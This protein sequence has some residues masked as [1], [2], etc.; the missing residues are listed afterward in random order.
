[1]VGRRLRAAGAYK[2][3]AEQNVAA[4]ARE[5]LALM[6]RI[7]RGE[8]VPPKRFGDLTAAASSGQDI[9]AYAQMTPAQRQVARANLERNLAL[10][11]GV[12]SQV[13]LAHA[14]RAERPDDL[15][16]SQPSAGS[17]ACL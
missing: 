10:E 8:P 13:H 1:M 3:G 16:G 12:P 11:S 15:V 9:S 2:T 7:D 5:Q 4:F 6:D 17:E 14:A